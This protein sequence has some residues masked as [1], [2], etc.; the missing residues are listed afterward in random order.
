MIERKLLF[1]A[2]THLVLYTIF[3]DDVSSAPCICM[4]FFTIADKTMNRFRFSSV[5]AA[6][7]HTGCKFIQFD[8]LLLT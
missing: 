7:I 3:N 5:I 1:P 4:H 2:N 6:S 8:D